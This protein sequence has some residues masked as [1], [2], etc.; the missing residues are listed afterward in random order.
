MRLND[1]KYE[2]MLVK[3]DRLIERAMACECFDIFT[4]PGL[5]IFYDISYAADSVNELFIK[6][7]FD[8]CT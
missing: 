1:R 6:W 5:L 3:K 7:I 8:F 2:K 4:R